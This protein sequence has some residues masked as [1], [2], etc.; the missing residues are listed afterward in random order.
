MKKL[1][2]K[3]II[4][5]IDK[6]VNRI[7][8]SDYRDELSANQELGDI[9]QMLVSLKWDIIGEDNTEEEGEEQ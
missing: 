2:K 5:R 1:S 3:Q 6:M 9:R 8:S 7:D 4:K